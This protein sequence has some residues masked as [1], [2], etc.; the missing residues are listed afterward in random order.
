MLLE[1]L[2]LSIIPITYFA[3]VMLEIVIAIIIFNICSIAIE[4]VETLTNKIKTKIK[5]R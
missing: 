5:G 2:K 3:I 4:Y 1:M